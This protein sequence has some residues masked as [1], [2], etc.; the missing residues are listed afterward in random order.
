[1]MTLSGIKAGLLWDQVLFQKQFKVWCEAQN[2]DFTPI[3][4]ISQCCEVY[5][6]LPSH[7][8][9]ILA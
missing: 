8:K 4:P 6:M 1:M 7:F 2:L 5:P 9:E 3:D